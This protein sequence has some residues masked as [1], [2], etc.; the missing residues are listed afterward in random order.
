MA[1][2]FRHHRSAAPG[3]QQEPEINPVDIPI[4]IQIGGKRREGFS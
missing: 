4:L 3:S 2:H 1:W